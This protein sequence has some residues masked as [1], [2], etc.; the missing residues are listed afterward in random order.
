M[1]CRKC[2]AE[3]KD[4]DIFCPKCGQKVEEE[5]HQETV[6][7]EVVFK[8]QRDESLCNVGFIFCVIGT[9]VLGFA[10]FPLLWCIPMTTSFSEKAKY[11]EK[12]GVGFKICTLLFVSFIAGILLFC[13]NENNYD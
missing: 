7:Q 1:Y 12:V 9:V 4:G 13:R 8:R 3:L 11:G 6:R 5:V 10:I 2:G